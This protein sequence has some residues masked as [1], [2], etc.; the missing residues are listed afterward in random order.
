[1]LI[2]GA[3]NHGVVALLWPASGYGHPAGR[4]ETC[5]YV[6]CFEASPRLG[7]ARAT[8]RMLT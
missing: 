4:F 7:F 3:I 2:L 1:M 6:R 8:T 5:P